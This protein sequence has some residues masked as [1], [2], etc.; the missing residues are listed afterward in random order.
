VARGKAEACMT[1][2]AMNLDILL[3][4]LVVFLFRVV[5]VSL[6]SMRSIYAV[7]GLRLRAAM[8]G[9]V[10]AGIFIFAI[11]WV[12]RDLNYYKMVAY[13]LG[14]ATGNFL[15]ITLEQWI[16]TGHVL[17]R[18]ITDSVV[19]EMVQRIRAEGFGV[20]ILDGQGQSGPRQILFIVSLR[21]RAGA[22]LSLVRELDP[23][24]F[25]TVEPVNQIIGGYI[26]RLAQ[27]VS[28]RK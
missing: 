13:A 1:E 4:A 17:V 9:L 7:R 10:E 8:L 19:T 26:P 11:T 28:V 3:G 21:R 22:L 6:G 5:D 2:P 16:A 20:T 12:M 25:V 15:G 18:V 24:A 23:D 14:F 27:T